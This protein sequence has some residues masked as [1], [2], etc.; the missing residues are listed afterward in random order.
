MSKRDVDGFTT[1]TAPGV[2][3]GPCIAY[4]DAG[5]V[6]RKP[7]KFICIRRRGVVCNE[8]RCDCCGRAK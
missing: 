1:E 8:H 3:L 7:S 4:D 5:N 6:C 2:S